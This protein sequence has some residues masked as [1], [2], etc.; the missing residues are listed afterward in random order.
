MRVTYGTAGGLARPAAPPS[1]QHTGSVVPAWGQGP[2]AWAVAGT[3]DHTDLFDLITDSFG[4]RWTSLRGR[5]TAGRPLAAGPAPFDA[6]A[7]ARA[8]ESPA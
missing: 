6:L 2:G 8:D 4:R 7:D 5:P 3:T 1:Q